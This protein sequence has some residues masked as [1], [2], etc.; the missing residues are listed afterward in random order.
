MSLTLLYHVLTPSSS[1]TNAILSAVRTTLGSF[2]NIAAA[3]GVSIRSVERWYTQATEKRKPSPK[4]L[5]KLA[6]KIAWHIVM[7]AQFCYQQT[8]RAK[9]VDIILEPSETKGLQE[10]LLAGNEEAALEII[11]D[12][13]GYTPSSLQE[14]SFSVVE[15]A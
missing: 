3:A 5:A 7:K 14:V 1:L 10:H 15:P 13:Y 6:K 9:M 4:T 8:C 12:A 11:T 2:K